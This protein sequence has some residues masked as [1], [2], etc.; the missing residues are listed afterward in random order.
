MKKKYCICLGK[1]KEDLSLNEKT[2]E[3]SLLMLTSALIESFF[4][5]IQN[6]IE[7]TLASFE[8]AE[9]KLNA[10][11][12]TKTTL[13]STM[14]IAPTGSGL[15]PENIVRHLNTNELTIEDKRVLQEITELRNAV[16]NW[17]DKRQLP[18]SR[19]NQGPEPT[20]K[21]YLQIALLTAPIK[22]II[23]CKDIRRIHQ[24]DSLLPLAWCEIWHALEYGIRARS[25]PYCGLVFLL[26]P[27][28][29]RKTTC[30]RPACKMKYEIDRHGGI[31]AY[32][33]WERNR[34]K[35]PSKRSPGRP[36]INKPADERKKKKVG[37][38]RKDV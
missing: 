31:E 38:P 12:D 27:N 20:A 8:E 5:I 6:N 21:E 29:P 10:I 3:T 35:L 22:P 19:Q 34:K 24:A 1:S 26:P 13:V 33:E 16:V 2:H 17:I 23:L 4:P 37:R 15:L 18:L 25:C 11:L 36:K 14:S 30:L 7:T 32:R 28:N 9:T